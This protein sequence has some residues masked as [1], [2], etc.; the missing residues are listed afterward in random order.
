M[1]V[2]TLLSHRFSIV[3][4]LDSVVPMLENLARRYG[5]ESRLASVRVVDIPVLDLDAGGLVDA[6]AEQSLL[7]VEEDGAHAIVF[8]CTG[9]EGH[10]PRIAEAL[11]AAGHP[12]IPVI[13]P[14]LTAL[15]LAEAVVELGLAQ[16]QA[17]WASPP[18]KEIT[19]YDVAA[20]A[21]AAGRP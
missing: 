6:L 18:P 12:G 11:A 5:V 19:G 9:M 21:A 3:T 16:S 10:A 17:T 2:A 13:D 8:G 7:A 1:L 14:V 20:P 4:V 15:K